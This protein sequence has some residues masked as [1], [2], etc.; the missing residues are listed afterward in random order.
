[1]PIE[2]DTLRCFSG[3]FNEY[4][5]DLPVAKAIDEFFETEIK[6]NILNNMPNG[7]SNQAYVQGFY[8]ETMFF[9]KYANIFEYI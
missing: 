3:W 4:L 7:L 2:S 1:M 5:A 6:E 9:F 8:C